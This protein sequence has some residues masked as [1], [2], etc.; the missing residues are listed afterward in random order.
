MGVKLWVSSKRERGDSAS[1]QHTAATD[2]EDKDKLTS[3]DKPTAENED[4]RVDWT[5]GATINFRTAELARAFRATPL[6]L[7]AHQPRPRPPERPRVRV[8]V[9]PPAEPAEEWAPTKLVRMLQ[10]I[11]DASRR[12]P[13]AADAEAEAG[14][15]ATATEERNAAG[16]AAPAPADEV[17]DLPQPDSAAGAGDVEQV[18]RQRSEVLKS[19]WGR[20]ET[21]LDPGGA[22]A[23]HVDVA[24]SDGEQEAEAEAE[25]ARTEMS[26]APEVSLENPL[27]VSNPK[28][29]RAH[30]PERPEATANGAT[31][32]APT[33]WGRH[34]TEQQLA[35]IAK[36]AVATDVAE[37]DG[38]EALTLRA[39]KPLPPESGLVSVV[40]KAIA[41]PLP[42]TK[43]REEQTR[44]LALRVPGADV[45]AFA[46]EPD[47][48]EPDVAAAAVLEEEGEEHEN[49]MVQL[50]AVAL[51][52]A[53]ARERALEAELRR[54]RAAARE[55]A[56]ETARVAAEAQVRADFGAFGAL[57][58]V[59]VRGVCVPVHWAPSR[60][61]DSDA[62]S[63]SGSGSGYDDPDTNEGRE[64]VYE[65]H[66]LVAFA[67]GV[68]AGC[69]RTVVPVQ[70][71]AYA[72]MG[73]RFMADPW[74]EA[75]AG[76]R[77]AAEGPEAP[78]GA[79]EGWARRLDRELRAEARARE[80]EKERERQRGAA[81]GT[82]GKENLSEVRERLRRAKRRAER[83]QEREATRA[84]A[85]ALQAEL[86]AEE[87]AGAAGGSAVDGTGDT[88][89]DE[90][91]IYSELDSDSTSSS[92]SS[93]SS[94]SE[95]SDSDSGSDSESSDSDS[96]SESESDESTPSEPSASLPYV[97]RF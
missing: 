57:E 22:A 21:T 93:G 23:R 3:K 13:G 68:A 1:A 26:G 65:M 97:A 15:A 54:A 92:S 29:G 7:E 72:D 49:P 28:E 63:G 6:L 86:R 4:F 43:L 2:E 8:H 84:W 31:D 94:D 58:G 36:D 73:V 16:R 96:G 77:P 45:P 11:L 64:W 66:A 55:S 35:E 46:P 89:S 9:S 82:W 34:P 48:T 25:A 38:P 27:P 61:A 70:L 51:R 33:G 30:L 20:L 74:P 19:M 67:D 75:L 50:Y 60:R 79:R 76:R 47:T 42:H 32:V 59:W 62:G 18:L 14:D 88:V 17:V 12:G 87:A 52:K 10:G 53:L 37:A 80:R 90:D 5:L 40:L 69:A 78:D 83:E 41:S 56:L 39:R 24:A 71:P 85:R 95:F 44:W 91:W 81:V